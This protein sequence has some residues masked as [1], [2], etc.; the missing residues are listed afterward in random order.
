M[1]CDTSW[2]SSQYDHQ[3]FLNTVEGPGG[4]AVLLRLKHPVT[5]VDT[6]RGL[7]LTTDGNHRWCAV[8]PRAGTAH[9][10][11]ESLLNLAC[12]GARPIAVVNCLNFGNPEHPEVMWQL[13]EAVDGM[14]EACLAFELPVIGGNVSLYNESKGVNI[15][16][17][18]VIGMLG[19][20]DELRRRPPGVS[21]AEGDVLVLLGDDLAGAEP[22]LAG[23]LVAWSAGDRNGQLDPI[24]FEAVKRLAA[25]VRGL[26]G[27]GRVSGIHDVSNGGLALA[28][29]EL[30]V[31]SGWGAAVDVV[32]SVAHLFAETPGRIVVAVPAAA[33][34]P[35]VTAAQDAGVAHVVLGSVGGDRLTVSGAGGALVDVELGR[36]V[37]TWRDRLPD[38]LGAGTTQA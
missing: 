38:A 37:D 26:V 3:L 19:V 21:Q 7:A 30:A 34:D 22:S 5:G 2:V 9:T 15:D 25:L 10:V 18:P 17:T 1:L 14:S 12:V 4:D 20:V 8:D 29:A 27:E 28:L 32:P 13:S 23:S 31:R 6:G 33:V 35:V 36:L 11:A 16:P 24:D